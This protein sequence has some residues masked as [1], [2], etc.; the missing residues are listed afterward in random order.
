MGLVMVEAGSSD[1]FNGYGNWCSSDFSEGPNLYCSYLT[2]ITSMDGYMLLHSRGFMRPLLKGQIF[3][4]AS[5]GGIIVTQNF[6]LVS[7][8]DGTPVTFRGNFNLVT[9]DHVISG[10]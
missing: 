4:R 1:E 3:R 10:C 7:I 2:K 5:R 8:V 9:R 6:P